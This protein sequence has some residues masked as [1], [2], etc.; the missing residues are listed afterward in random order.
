[1]SRTALLLVIVMSTTIIGYSTGLD[2]H[3]GRPG[4]RDRYG[5]HYGDPGNGDP[6]G[7]HCHPPE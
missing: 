1:M 5:C 2:A 6:P 4:D 7:R 3:E